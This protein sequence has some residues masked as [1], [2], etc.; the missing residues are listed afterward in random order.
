MTTPT[1]QLIIFLKAPDISKCKTRLIPL[2]GEQGATD[3]YIDLATHCVKKLHS[4]NTVDITLFCY[5][6]IQHN[7]FKH[8]SKTYHVGLQAQQGRDLGERM[9]NAI[10]CS[11]HHYDQSVLIGS[12]C[13]YITAEYIEQAYNALNSHDIALGP[14]KDGG[15]VLIGARKVDPELF[16]NT[17]WSSHTV[18]QQ[19]LDN[20]EKLNYSHYL[21]PELWDIDTPDDFIENQSQIQT[22]LNKQYYTGL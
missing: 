16:T 11:L 21:L 18:L 3:F 20:I 19:C 13:P 17:Q 8:L 5:P 4:L 6:D 9:Y 1:R 12:D 15:Y 7:F 10:E 22:L 2:F 14:A